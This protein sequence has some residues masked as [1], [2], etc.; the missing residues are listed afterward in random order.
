M[1][2]AADSKGMQLPNIVRDVT[3]DCHR[4]A[5]PALSSHKRTGPGAFDRTDNNGETS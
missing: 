3:N 5:V 2:V 4:Y 1:T